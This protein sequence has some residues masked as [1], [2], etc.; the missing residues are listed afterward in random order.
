ML[1]SSQIFIDYAGT[2]SNLFIIDVNCMY[3]GLFI[4]KKLYC[5]QLQVLQL[6]K[7]FPRFHKTSARAYRSRKSI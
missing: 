2:A 5:K 3:E 4:A 1:A 7:N 6:K